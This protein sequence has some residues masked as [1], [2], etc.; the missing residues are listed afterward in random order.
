MR[1]RPEIAA[2]TIKVTNITNRQV[3]GGST[4]GQRAADALP[5]IRY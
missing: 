1:R 5:N 3:I 4:N 2:R